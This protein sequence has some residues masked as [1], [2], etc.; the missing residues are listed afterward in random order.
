MAGAARDLQRAQPLQ[1]CRLAD[2]SGHPVR[3]RDRGLPRKPFER[4]AKAT[5][6][7]DGLELGCQLPPEAV[8]PLLLGASCLGPQDRFGGHDV[9]GPGPDLEA[10]RRRH[11]ACPEPLDGKDRLGRPRE[12]VPPQAHRGRAGMI[13]PTGDAGNQPV[14]AGDARHHADGDPS[15]L[16]HRPLFDVQLDVAVQVAAPN[17]P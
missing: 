12:G 4:C 15:G 7:S 9:E 8:Q 6:P 11:A 5:P 17:A 16:E 1:S 13:R 3:H 10:P 2:S 14:D